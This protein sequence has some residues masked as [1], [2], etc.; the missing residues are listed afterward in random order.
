MSQLRI[1]DF[2]VKPLEA[3][4]VVVDR[5]NRIAIGIYGSVYVGKF[6]NEQVA[7]KEISIKGKEAMSWQEL[8]NE[9]QISSALRHPNIVQFLGYTTTQNFVWD[10]MLLV[11]ELIEG[12]NL[13][14]IIYDE[15]CKEMDQTKKKVINIY[16]LHELH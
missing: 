8:K 16:L 15:Q 12:S 9:I 10:T 13:E 11:Y 2:G 5:M 7:V 3:N 4:E 14:V 1:D 6:K